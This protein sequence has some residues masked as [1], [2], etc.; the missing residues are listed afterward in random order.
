MCGAA[1]VLQIAWALLHQVVT[2]GMGSLVHL[3][4]LLACLFLA[5]APAISAKVLNAT[6]L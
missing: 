4:F 3:E 1:C 6:K 2:K 5:S